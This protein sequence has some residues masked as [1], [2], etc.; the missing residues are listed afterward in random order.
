MINRICGCVCVMEKCASLCESRKE[1][2]KNFTLFIR[3][4]SIC[5]GKQ[6]NYFEIRLQFSLRKSVKRK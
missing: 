6:M 1:N 3:I 2:G 4:E 5:F